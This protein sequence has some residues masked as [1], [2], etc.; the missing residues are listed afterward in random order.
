M[1]VRNR[2]HEINEYKADFQF[3]HVPSY[4]NPADLLSRGQSLKL[5][6]KSQLWFQGPS[7]LQTGEWP[8]QKEHVVI[9]EITTEVVQQPTFNPLFDITN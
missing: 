2:V 3:L 9:H 5:F 8:I 4:S 1:Y 7:W 6:K